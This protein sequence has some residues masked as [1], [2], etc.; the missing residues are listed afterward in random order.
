MALRGQSCKY[1]VE[2]LRGLRELKSGARSA[3]TGSEQVQDPFKSGK[4]SSRLLTLHIKI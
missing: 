4:D 3:Q 1:S 2:T